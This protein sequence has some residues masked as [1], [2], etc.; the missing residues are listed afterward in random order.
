[1]TVV[2]H[3]AQ[4][5][6]TLHAETLAVGAARLSAPESAEERARMEERVAQIRHLIE[7]LDLL[8]DAFIKVRTSET[9]SRDLARI[10]KWLQR[11]DPRRLAAIS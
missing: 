1:M 7:T 6:W 11:E 2:R 5:E 9:W 8:F 3:D 4:Y 10:Q